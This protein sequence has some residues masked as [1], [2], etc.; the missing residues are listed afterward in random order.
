M[1]LAEIPSFR[2]VVT[3]RA[4]K[5]LIFFLIR[6]T[7]CVYVY[8]FNAMLYSVVGHSQLRCFIM[9]SC[10]DKY[11]MP[12]NANT[13]C[14]VEHSTYLD[15]LIKLNNKLLRILQDKPVKFRTD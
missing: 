10:I 7:R 15:R 2:A 5:R 12:F 14:T 1:P 4:V 9:Y 8:A 11:F 6:V 13:C 3:V